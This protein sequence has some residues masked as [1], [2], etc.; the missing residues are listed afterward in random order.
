M[1]GPEMAVPAA[2]ASDADGAPEVSVNVEV[3]VEA[4]ATKAP[5]M[6]GAAFGKQGSVPVI[7]GLDELGDWFGVTT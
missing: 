7:V 2:N 5:S 6:L 1:P 4:M 3:L